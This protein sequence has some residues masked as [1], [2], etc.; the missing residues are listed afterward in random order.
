MAQLNH[1]TKHTYRLQVLSTRAALFLPAYA[2]LLYFSIII[3]ELFEALTVPIA[4]VEG[5]SF[6]LFFALIVANMGGPN[7]CVRIMTE[8]GCKPLCCGGSCCPEEPAKYYTRTLS[9]L[10]YFLAVR[11]FFVLIAVIGAYAVKAMLAIYPKLHP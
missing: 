5:Y 4:V 7:N 6:Y 9:A 2:F 10:F 8:K 1:V 11:P 3:P